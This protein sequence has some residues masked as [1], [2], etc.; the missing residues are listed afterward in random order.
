MHEVRSGR[1]EQRVMWD[2]P[3]VSEIV[4]R[5]RM[6]VTDGLKVGVEGIKDL[7]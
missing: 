6:G 2:M 3:E 4:V 5:S 7:L 1:E